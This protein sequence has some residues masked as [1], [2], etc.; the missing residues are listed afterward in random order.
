MDSAFFEDQ[1]LVIYVSQPFVDGR[2]DGAV[3]LNSDNVDATTANVDCYYPRSNYIAKLV[4]DCRDIWRFAVPWNSA[5]NC[6][7]NQ[8][9]EE[10]FLV[11][12]GQ[13]IV[14]N[15]EYLGIE[16]WRFIRAVLRIKLRF[17]RF[18]T[19]VTD[20]PASVFNDKIT[21]AAITK[22]LVAVSLTDPAVVELT[23]VLQYPYKLYNGSMGVAPQGKVESYVFTFD[24]CAGNVNGTECRQN[25]RTTLKLTE[26][27]CTLDGTYALNW[28]LNCYE[29]AI[30][31]SAL[32]PL[33]KAEDFIAAVTYKL[34]SENFCATLTIDVGLVGNLRSYENDTFGDVRTAFI[35][36]R[37]G[38]FLVKV[39]SELNT[40]KNSSNGADADLY[41]VGGLGT[42]VT[43]SKITL[44]TV[45]V[46][47]TTGTPV[48]LYEN[49]A[50]AVFEASKD[51]NTSCGAVTKYLNGN[52][53]PENQVGFQFTFTRKLASTLLR[54]QKVDFVISA[55][56]QVTYS[57]TGAKKRFNMEALA[58]T[59]EDN[60]DFTGVSTL[61]DNGEGPTEVV[62]DTTAT[63][64]TTATTTSAT[65]T[66][67]TD[68]SNSVVLV[69]SFLVMILTLLF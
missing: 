48:R 37:K 17:Q 64:A 16:Y 34:K 35:V 27:T 63:T 32:C 47:T 3:F 62:T 11:Y 40:P 51:L 67:K 22:Q 54:N 1:K 25:W 68:T 46:R 43:F 69:A 14:H 52:N 33:S 29:A 8:T 23:T 12:R 39:N 66:G 26:G 13:V 28:T 5:K 45:T 50:P 18:V 65:S 42:V 6:G 19:V 15:Q 2:A 10:N 61:D 31:S 38:Y 60:G 44:V 58:T 30:G 36:G 56:V 24:N 9:Q 55:E 4:E 20:T 49:K 7:W 59:G 57:N 21:S 53:L 41:V